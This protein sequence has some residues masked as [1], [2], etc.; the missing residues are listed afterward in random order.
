MTSAKALTAPEAC[1]D[2]ARL[3]DAGDPRRVILPR[4]GR[5]PLNFMGRKASRTVWCTGAEAG[6]GAPPDE[7]ALWARTDGR[8]A[9]SLRLDGK[10]DAAVVADLG[11]ALD[12]IEAA[13][14]P[15]RRDATHPQ[16][17][18]ALLE[19]LETWLCEARRAERLRRL[20]GLALP[21]WIGLRD[22]IGRKERA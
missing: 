17:A 5:K 6:A 1:P 10:D 9:I 4:A 11:A 12:W 13:C 16:D 21:Q 3:P 20:A 15:Q 2:P 7:L 8:L 19:Q 14:R 18:R 22:G